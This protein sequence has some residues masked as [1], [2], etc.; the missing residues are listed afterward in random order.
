MNK[1]QYLLIKIAEEA[2]EI[3]KEAL[4]CA[5]FGMDD[6]YPDGSAMTTA[7]R[8]HAEVN[9]L[10]AAL[11]MLALEIGHKPPSTVELI[12]ESKDISERMKKIEKYMEYS[13]QRG[14]LK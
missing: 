3:S 6:R 4:K 8:M 1:V 13:R 9:D 10:M 7:E 12:E 5:R 2:S 11:T 14:A